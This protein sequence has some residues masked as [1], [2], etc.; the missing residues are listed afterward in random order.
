LGVRDWFKKRRQKKKGKESAPEPEKPREPIAEA[1]EELT[2]EPPAEKTEETAP[3]PI[4]EET[5]V[6]SEPPTQET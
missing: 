5:E 1:P 6:A 4:A 3:E 2:P